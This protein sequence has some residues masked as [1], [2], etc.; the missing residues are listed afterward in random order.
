MSHQGGPDATLIGSAEE[1]E[2]PECG[3]YEAEDGHKHHPA[4]RVVHEDAGRCHQDPHQASKHLQGRGD[5]GGEGE[6]R[7]SL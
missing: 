1:D 6:V 5:K 7:Q 2:E 3:Q 4:Q